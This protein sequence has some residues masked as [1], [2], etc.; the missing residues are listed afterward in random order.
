MA[1]R[2]KT[3]AKPKASRTRAAMG[4][5][6]GKSGGK[7]AGK[8]AGKG[9]SKK[10]GKAAAKG[11]GK[12]VR[13]TAKKVGKAVRST[14]KKVGK[15]VRSTA[16]KVGKAVRSTAKRAGK[17]VRPTA[18]GVVN[19]A[20]EPAR[21]AGSG[22]SRSPSPAASAERPS[23]ASGGAGERARL[24]P[25]VT[26]ALKAAAWAADWV[27]AEGR[28]VW[29]ELLTAD[30]PAARAFY[31]SLFGWTF[32]ELALGGSPRLVLANGGRNIGSI[33][34]DE[35]LAVSRW[36]SHLAVGDVDDV[37]RRVRELGGEVQA[38]ASVLP[39]VGTFAVAVDPLGG[40]FSAL[41]R[42]TDV[43]PPPDPARAAPGDFC[44]EELYTTEPEV[45]AR[46]YSD[47]LGWTVEPAALPE[48]S[49]AEASEPAAEASEPA[50]ESWE[51]AGDRSDGGVDPERPV[52]PVIG[53]PSAE[54]DAAQQPYWI[55]RNGG[56][57]VA[58]IVLQPPGAT[59]RPFWLPY[60]AVSDVEASASQAVSL[61]GS[62]LTPPT[63]IPGLG[64]FAVLVDPVGASFAVY[65]SARV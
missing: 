12:A 34:P 19:G 2:T 5:P 64:R 1:T 39:G 8:S 55:A 47:L 37:C 17:A 11:T 41:R 13:S 63:D 20:R 9:G 52:D 42:P 3:K 45:A 40:S 61:G 27:A 44:W 56:L 58:G 32:D 49:E 54:P 60:I 6:A 26:A 50:G 24:S 7:S 22:T 65:R 53:Q 23:P 28:F 21:G 31:G 16:K 18:K 4:K 15:A 51:S 48:A 57:D 46:F 43:A 59:Y 35:S 14:A 33:V 38:G 36:T 25:R 29:H 62:V 30:P 10:P